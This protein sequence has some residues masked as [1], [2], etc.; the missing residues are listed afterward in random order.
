MANAH[1]GTAPNTRPY[2]IPIQVITVIYGLLYLVFFIYSFISS[3]T[4]N[5]VSDLVPFDAWDTE[6][7]IVKLLFLV[8]LAGFYWSWRSRLKA[9]LIYV[10]WFAGLVGLSFWVAGVLHRDGDMAIVMGLPLFVIGLIL[11]VQ[12]YRRRA[13]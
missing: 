7:I 2:S 3:D 6:Q 11:V 4:G 1:P 13:V 5:P 8:F 9:G 10:A 12:G